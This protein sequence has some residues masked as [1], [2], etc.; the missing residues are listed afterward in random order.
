MNK[1]T[2]FCLA[3][4]LAL[5]VATPV[6]AQN[7]QQ[8][9]Y[10]RFQPWVPQQVTPGQEQR[11]QQGDYY[12]THQFKRQHLTSAQKQRMKQGDYYMSTR[13]Y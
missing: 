8:G 4:M 9:D 3:S 11:I 13:H 1:T 12:K 7:A 2:K 5:C 6:L 10:Y